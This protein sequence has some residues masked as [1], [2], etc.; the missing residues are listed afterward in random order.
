MINIKGNGMKCFLDCV[1][2]NPQQ[3]EKEKKNSKKTDRPTLIFP[4]Q[5]SGN[6]QLIILGLINYFEDRSL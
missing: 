5:V 3:M 4:E 6:T 2:P 1:F